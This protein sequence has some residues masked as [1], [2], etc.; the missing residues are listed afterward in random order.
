[1][2]PEERAKHQQVSQL[3]KYND[4]IKE[5]ERRQAMLAKSRDAYLRFFYV[6]PAISLVAFLRNVGTG[7]AALFTALIMTLFGIYTVLVREGDYR[8]G[9][10]A[11]RAEAAKLKRAIGL[12]EARA[13]T[14]R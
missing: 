8:A 2:S 14:I 1:M 12:S 7:A 5:L 9:L 3:D 4:W 10:R 6:L 13:R 11:A